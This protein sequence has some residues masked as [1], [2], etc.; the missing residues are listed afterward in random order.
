MEFYSYFDQFFFK[1]FGMTN[2]IFKLLSIKTS[3]KW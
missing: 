1:S 3:E 2:L